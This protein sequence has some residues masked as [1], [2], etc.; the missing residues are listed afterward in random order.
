[1]V[2]CIGGRLVHSVYAALDVPDLKIVACSDS[3]IALWWLKNRGD[4]SVFVAKREDEI[5]SP[6]PFQ[7]W[8]HEPGKSNPVDLISRGSSCRSFSDFGRRLHSR[9]L[10]VL[11]TGR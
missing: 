3:I 7:F 6:V 9:S 10:I 11:V 1:M 5:N 8:R 4:W 2:C